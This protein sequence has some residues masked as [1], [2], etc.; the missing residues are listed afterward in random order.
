MPLFPFHNRTNHIERVLGDIRRGH[1][2][3]VRCGGNNV[4]ILPVEH[5]TDAIFSWLKQL[6]P[7]PFVALT[8]QRV[9]HISEDDAASSVLQLPL[10]DTL[11]SLQDISGMSGKIV[12]IAQ[13][14][15][16]GDVSEVAI[17]SM[18]LAERL[19]AVVIFEGDAVSG[20]L[21]DLLTLSDE[22]IA[23]YQTQVEEGLQQVCEAP[24]TLKQAEDVRIVVFRAAS[25]GKEHYAIVVGNPDAQDAP[26][27]R[28]HSS[29]YTGD[30]LNSLKCD[31]RDQLHE[32]LASMREYG[33]GVIL[34]MMQEGRGIGLV[35][36][37][38]A[39]RLQHEGY[40]T[41]DANELLGFDDDERPFAAAASMLQSLGYTSV[42]LMT[43][44]PRKAAQLEACGVEV[45]ER[46]SHRMQDNVHNK[47]YL[48]TKF[49]RLGHLA[50]GE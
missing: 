22:D 31:C 37:L 33:A 7:V 40:D 17:A 50:E 43:N 5:I 16:A 27:V 42:R 36:K 41:V 47:A 12:K 18:K 29:C 1:P 19:P 10:P 13:A 45:K 28:V 39:Y 26:P 11:V 25:S 20:G 49:D 24:L 30:L 4:V 9:K 32:A 6:S 2:V 8:S 34:Y 15:P 48:D 23:F 46:I 44:N 35:N 21:Q 3:S 14:Q 38:R